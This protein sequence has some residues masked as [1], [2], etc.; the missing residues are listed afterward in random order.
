MRQLDHPNVLKYYDY[1][2]DYD[3]KNENA[4]VAIVT[5]FCSVSF[6]TCQ[7]KSVTRYSLSLFKILYLI[8]KQGTIKTHIKK[9][10][11]SNEKIEIDLI[12]KWSFE[13]FNT[14]EYLHFQKKIIHRDIKPE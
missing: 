12:E 13:M 4:S 1:F 7:N 9:K 8:F 5:D 11:E 6:S 10:I 14:L 2:L 3:L